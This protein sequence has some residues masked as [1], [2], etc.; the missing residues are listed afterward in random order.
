MDS[1]T[2]IATQPGTAS[3][4]TITITT[5]PSRSSSTSTLSDV[6]MLSRSP[7]PPSE[8]HVGLNAAIEEGAVESKGDEV[9][10]KENEMEYEKGKE[11]ELWWASTKATDGPEHWALFVR[12]RGTNSCIHYEMGNGYPPDT[13]EPWRQENMRFDSWGYRAREFITYM[14]EEDEKQMQV[15]VT[16][17]WN[18]RC[19]KYVVDILQRL[20]DIDMVPEGTAAKY[21]ARVQPFGL[22]EGPV[23][24]VR[25]ATFRAWEKMFGKEEAKLKLK[26]Y[27]GWIL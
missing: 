18:G 7:T 25:P 4:E 22:F 15:E 11:L 20:E 16:W 3:P 13:Y 23:G 27:Q 10:S 9:E 1:Q 17:V 5:M 21:R 19:Q 26:Q 2:T 24:P 8:V 6:P 12:R 14:S